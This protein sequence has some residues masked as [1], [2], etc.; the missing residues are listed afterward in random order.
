[1]RTLVIDDD[2]ASRV[3]SCAILERMG[4]EASA[5]SDGEAGLEQLLSPDP[6]SLAIVD[7]MMPGLDGIGL[8]KR[9]REVA[10]PHYTYVILVTG[11]H[12]KEDTVVGLDAGADDFLSKPVEFSEFRSRVRVGERM[13]RLESSLQ[14]RVAEL[15]TALSHVKRLEGLLPI[16]MHCKRIRDPANAWHRIE[17]YITE[18]SEAQFSHGI[19]SECLEEHYPETPA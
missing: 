3:L 5:V 16:C 17:A 7:W 4:H 2:P 10:R 8:C 12:T 14:L 18:R 9:L 19:C 6:P 13:A 1:M 15:E 11:R